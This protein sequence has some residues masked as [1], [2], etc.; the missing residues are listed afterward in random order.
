MM[1]WEILG[2]FSGI[3]FKILWSLGGTLM[4]SEDMDAKS[5]GARSK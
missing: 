4:S 1:A 3:K 5:K 2:V